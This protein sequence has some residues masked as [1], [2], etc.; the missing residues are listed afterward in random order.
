[1]GRRIFA[2]VVL[3]A[4]IVV[5]CNGARQ[6][7]ADTAPTGCVVDGVFH[8]NGSNW[9]TG[10]CSCDDATPTDC[11]T[12]MCY[13]GELTSDGLNVCPIPSAPDAYAGQTCVTPGGEVVA[14]GDDITESESPVPGCYGGPSGSSD[15]CPSGQYMQTI[16]LLCTNGVLSPDENS[17]PVCECL[18]GDA[19]T[20][21]ETASDADAASDVADADADAPEGP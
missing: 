16:A 18:A 15:A 1:M 14:N 13:D 21:T 7:P 2:S 11:R 6:A 9:Q 3:A 4:A 19:E 10:D 5:G 17:D 8:P 20:G 12:Y